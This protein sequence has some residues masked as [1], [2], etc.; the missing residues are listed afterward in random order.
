MAALGSAPEAKDLLGQWEAPPNQGDTL[1]VPLSYL[2]RH[3]TE[4]L[5]RLAELCDVAPRPTG[6]EILIVR[7]LPSDDDLCGFRPG[8]VPTTVEKDLWALLLRIAAEQL[9]GPGRRPAVSASKGTLVPLH[10]PII[11]RIEGELE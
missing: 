2:A 3:H 7:P 4:A 5:Q 11:R 8:K 6:R 9:F 10:H 1:I